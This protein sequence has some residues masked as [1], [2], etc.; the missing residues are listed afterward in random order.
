[1][2][3][4]MVEGRITETVLQCLTT[5]RMRGMMAPQMVWREL[6]R[7]AMEPDLSMEHKVD[8]GVQKGETEVIF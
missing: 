6:S 8:I 7:L 1:M 4:M 3:S 5:Y 2:F